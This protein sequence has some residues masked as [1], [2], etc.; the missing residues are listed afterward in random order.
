[1]PTLDFLHPLP[2]A[3]CL[4]PVGYPRIPG[5]WAQHVD[6]PN[7]PGPLHRVLRLLRRVRRMRLFMGMRQ[8]R[9]TT[10]G[11]GGFLLVKPIQN[12]QE[13]GTLSK[14][15]LRIS[16]WLPT[17]AESDLLV[18]HIAMST[19]TCQQFYKFDPKTRASNPGREWGAATVST[20]LWEVLDPAAATGPLI[21]TSNLASPFI[22]GSMAGCFSSRFARSCRILNHHGLQIHRRRRQCAFG[23]AP[24]CGR[25]ARRRNRRDDWR[26]RP[27]LVERCGWKTYHL[28]RS[29]MC[30]NPSI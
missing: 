7:R 13:M 15:Q 20:A 26:V 1:M 5:S 25:F 12:H 16:F 4:M 29:L 3:V 11:T 17:L 28:R 23:Q 21:S 30:R 18:T 14:T 27:D 6:E 10:N 2:P 24:W 19:V 9:G 8:N 22:V